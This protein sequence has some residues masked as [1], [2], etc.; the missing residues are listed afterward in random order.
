MPLANQVGAITRV[1]Q[2]IRQA[3]H[4]RRQPVGAIKRNGPTRASAKTVLAGHDRRARGRAD[5]S[6]VGVIKDQPAVA[7]GLNAEHLGLL[8][9]NRIAGRGIQ[10]HVI[11]HDPQD[12]G[13]IRSLRGE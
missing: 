1:F 6:A 4:I 8:I 9:S 3:G 2:N 10:P 11:S 13:L 7:H 12:I 5:R